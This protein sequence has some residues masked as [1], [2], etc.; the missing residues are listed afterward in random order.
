MT[1]DV[2]VTPASMIEVEMAPYGLRGPQGEVGLQGLQGLQGEQGV[3]AVMVAGYFFRSSALC[4][5]NDPAG[6][7][8]AGSAS[9]VE[10]RSLS[11]PSMLVNVGGSALLLADGVSLD[12][13]SV[14]SW[15]SGAYASAGNRA[16][17]DFYLYACLPASGSVPDFVLSAESL[18]PSAIPSGATP[19]AG[20][21]R[22]IGG[23]HCLCVAVGTIGGHDL[24]GY[25]AGD[26]LP[27]SVWDLDFQPMSL[28][29]GMVFGRHGQWVDIYL[30]SVLGGELVSVNGGTIADGTSV[31]KFHPY[32]FDQWFGRIAK[33]PIA[34]LEFVAASL[35]ANQGTNIAGGIDPVTTGGHSDSAGRRMISNIGCEDMC[36]VMR[37][38]GREQGG[39]HSGSGTTPAFDTNDSGVG[40]YHSYAPVRAGFGGYWGESALC[41]SRNSLW[42]LSVLS[43]IQFYSS[44]GVSEMAC[45]RI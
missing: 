22:K 41:G 39:A 45:C 7:K 31:V 6:G 21:S 1:V 15:D 2:T 27:R 5:G 40:G 24:S 33:K 4:G 38:W 10:R 3:S 32:K 14:L 34:S 23:F 28:P 37:Q 44:R 16:G 8:Y 25:L 11:V 43:L 17:R 36:G 13:D 9:A 35:G 12:L 42:G 30:P 26:V 18:V 20:T 29:E 19:A